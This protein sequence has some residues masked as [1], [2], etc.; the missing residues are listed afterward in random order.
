MY[1]LK[2][3]LFYCCLRMIWIPSKQSKT[4]GQGKGLYQDQYQ[5]LAFK[6]NS[7]VKIKVK[8]SVKISVKSRGWES[9]QGYDHSR[10]RTRLRLRSV[11]SKTILNSRS[12]GIGQYDALINADNKVRVNF[13]SYKSEARVME[14]QGKGRPEVEV[15]N[16]LDYGWN[17]GLN[18]VKTMFK[19]KV[20]RKVMLTV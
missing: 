18:I 10:S 3:C 9:G 5:G 14:N 20:K 8:T 12:R 11:E 13:S 16:M 6:V 2:L 19:I 17:Q 15:V 7:K 1:N 4:K